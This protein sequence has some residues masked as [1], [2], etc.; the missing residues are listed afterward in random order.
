[1][2]VSVLRRPLRC[3]WSPR[4]PTT[5]SPTPATASSASKAWPSRSKSTTGSACHRFSPSLHLHRTW[6]RRLSRRLEPSTELSRPGMVDSEAALVWPEGYLRFLL[7]WFSRCEGFGAPLVF[8]LLLS[9][10]FVILQSWLFTFYTDMVIYVFWM[11]L[12]SFAAE[13]YIYI[14]K[15]IINNHSIFTHST[16]NYFI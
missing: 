11:N 2:I 4:V 9:A 8:W 16:F 3:H 12:K 10:R 6:N 5:T 15:N 1:M 14:F 7:R 13:I